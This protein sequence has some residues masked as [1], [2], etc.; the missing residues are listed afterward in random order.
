MYIFEQKKV[1]HETPISRKDE[2]NLRNK[3]KTIMTK[4]N[5]RSDKIDVI[6]LHPSVIKPPSSSRIKSD[7]NI[8]HYYPLY[9]SNAY[10]IVCW[11]TI[12]IKSRSF[13]F[14]AR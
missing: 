2:E 5:K 9:I 12:S 14:M 10:L 8:F 6:S 13:S 11:T 4:V 7:V 3:I 1:I